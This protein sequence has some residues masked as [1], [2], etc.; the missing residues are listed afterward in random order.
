MNQ[1]APSHA[2]EP[3]LETRRYLLP[4]ACVFVII[5][6]LATGILFGVIPSISLLTVLLAGATA[7]FLLFRVGQNYDVLNPVRVFGAVWCFCLALVSLKLTTTIS[8]WGP[9]MWAY[10]LAGLFSFI[11]GFWLL[12]GLRTR[13]QY[14]RRE[15]SKMQLPPSELLLAPRTVGLAVVCLGIGVGTLSYLYSQIGL[16][17]LLSGNIDAA[18]SQFTSPI[19]QGEANPQYNVLLNKII[20]LFTFFSKYAAYLSCILLFQKGRKSRLQIFV[21]RVLIV[22]GILALASQGIRSEVFHVLVVSAALFHYLSR[23]LRLKELAVIGAMFILLL[24]IAGYWRDAAGSRAIAHAR[25]ERWSRLPPGDFW[26]QITYGYFRITAPFETF[27]RLTRDLP[28]QP[29]PSS[30]YSFYFLHRF[31][32][33]ENL[34]DVAFRLYSQDMITPTFLGEFYADFGFWG[35][36]LGPLVLGLGYGYVYSQNERRQSLYWLFVKAMLVPL[37]LFFA[38]T[39]VFFR[40]PGWIWDMFCMWWLI[41]VASAGKRQLDATLSL[42]SKISGRI[43]DPITSTVRAVEPCRRRLVTGKS[44]G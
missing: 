24:S 42:E 27:Y 43:A 11:G 13:N 18:R 8:D 38:D 21:C 30:G 29:E 12:T 4:I 37:L 3:R 32:P 23:P 2:S 36:L 15:Y 19:G 40:Q 39:N 26:D 44:G 31:V 1:V 10:V 34:Q 41:K 14:P 33:R 6:V 20:I 9:T 7:V 17:P 22:G 25:A 5:P 16:V 35:I 28:A